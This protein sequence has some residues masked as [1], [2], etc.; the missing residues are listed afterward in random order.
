MRL[1]L[2]ILALF[3][4]GAAGAQAPKNLDARIVYATQCAA[5][6][7]DD[8]LGRIGPALLPENLGRLSKDKAI[9]TI[10]EGRQATQMPAFGKILSK[11]EIAALVELVYTP[12][13]QM[14]TWGEA[15]IKASR[16][17]HN[18]MDSLPDKPQHKS[19][20]LNLFTVVE[21]GD[22]HVTILDGDT[23]E[24]IWRFPSRFAVHGGAKY[25]PDGRF[26]YLGSRD[27]WVSKYDLWSLKPVAE[28]RVGINMR[29]IAVS[30][31]GKWIM[32]GNSLP[33][34]LVVLNAAD[35]TLYKI[36]PATDKDGNTSRI[37]A[38][39]NAP[40][41]QSFIVALKDFKEIWEMSYDPDAAPVYEGFVHNYRAGQEEGI[42]SEPQPFARK[43][44]Q[45]EDYLDDF[46]FDQDYTSV[47][48][49][50]RNGKGGAVYNLDVRRKVA[51]LD[52]D[53]MPH[54][55]SGITWI[56]KGR[57][58]MATPNL[59]KGA[60]SIID[61]ESWKT[62]KVIKTLGPGFFMRSHDNTPY[63]WVDVF[64]GPNRDA[65]HII[66]KRTLEIV[67]TLRP[68]PGKTAAHVEFTR[69]GAYALVSLWEKDGAIIVYDA[70][71]FKE[72]KRIPMNKPSGKYNVY[73][74]IT[75]SRGTS[76]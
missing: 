35:M 12:L 56:Y 29:N 51:D 16:V 26:V 31:D 22:H 65:I 13:P 66:D 10:A 9:S 47:M 53:G 38:V 64:F 40:P 48:G 8:R 28:I 57:P 30:S 50:S 36:I 18:S 33:H 69:D 74:K 37:S 68:E 1:F 23:F 19:D 54:L 60:V 45:T 6:H 76:H 71:T 75:Y 21:T 44:T 52:L 55:G 14:P 63:A 20:P 5:C 4:P 11:D 42:I 34:T 62:I 27:G 61:M 24:P 46:Y 41:R 43:R 58:V 25:S 17:V 70:K 59:R 3:I 32:A 2:F 73:N 49:A 72:V 67:K 7:G 39:Y 15:E